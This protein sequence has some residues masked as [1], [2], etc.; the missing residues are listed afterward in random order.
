MA[1]RKGA[2]RRIGAPLNAARCATCKAHWCFSCPRSPHSAP[3][4]SQSGLDNA[5]VTH[6]YCNHEFKEHHARWVRCLQ[7]S[8]FRRRIDAIKDA[9]PPSRGCKLPIPPL[10]HGLANAAFSCCA[11]FRITM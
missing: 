5:Q 9:T 7:R 3:D 6:H 4:G 1:G 10:L 11:R 2:V 8:G